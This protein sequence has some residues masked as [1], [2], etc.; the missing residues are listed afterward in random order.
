MY[1]LSLHLKDARALVDIHDI[2]DDIAIKLEKTLLR[3]LNQE[4]FIF[5]DANIKLHA[6]ETETIKKLTLVKVI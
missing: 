2:P 4:W 5:P 1:R 6:Y 3:R